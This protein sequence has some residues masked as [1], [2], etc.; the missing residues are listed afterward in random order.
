M[1]NRL[2][3]L[4]PRR[5]HTEEDLPQ[6]SSSSI[7]STPGSATNLSP[8]SG[9]VARGA[10]SLRGAG[11]L[12]LNTFKSPPKQQ[13]DGS[14]SPGEKQQQERSAERRERRR[15]SQMAALASDVPERVQIASPRTREEV[16]SDLP[17]EYFQHDFDPLSFE[18]KKL[19]C[20]VDEKMLEERAQE[21][22][23]ILEVLTLSLPLKRHPLLL[24]LPL[25]LLSSSSSRCPPPS[26]LQRP[27]P[28]PSP[29][30]REPSAPVCACLLCG[31][32]HRPLR[33]ST[34]TSRTRFSR[35][36]TP[37]STASTRSPGWS[38]TFRS[39]EP[40]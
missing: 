1:L 14:R 31:T 15:S 13:D 7:S 16:L 9:P 3:S 34:S 29:K 2:K 35:A 8:L 39:A 21:Q 11:N 12:L 18:L 19:P 4:G 25:L 40:E 26:P 10:S 28:P 27:P 30:P 36:P 38:T 23:L 32:P 5:R 17:E 37:S 24:L 33:S 6:A 20:D 22:V